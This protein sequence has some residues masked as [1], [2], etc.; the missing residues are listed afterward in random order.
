MYCTWACPSILCTCGILEQL[1]S[2]SGG[3]LHCQRNLKLSKDGRVG[4]PTANYQWSS[5]IRESTVHG[6][7]TQ[8]ETVQVCRGAR[9]GH[10]LL[11][12]KKNAKRWWWASWSLCLFL[13]C[14]RKNARF[15]CEWAQKKT[16]NKMMYKQLHPDADEDSF[17]ASHGWLEKF[18]T[19]HGIHQL[20]LQ[21]ES[22]SADTA[23]VEPFKEKFQELIQT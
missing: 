10:R 7:V 9:V 1:K 16:K 11:Q 14:A 4:V 23:S 3:C 6:I 8:R 15:S 18:K 17:K 2:E 19:R 21:G 22:L 20:R 12:A 5:G 13:V